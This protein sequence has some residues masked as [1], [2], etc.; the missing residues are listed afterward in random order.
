MSN[1]ENLVSSNPSTPPGGGN[2]G[3]PPA[4][5]RWYKIYAIFMAV[6]YAGLAY[7]GFYFLQN[8][9]VILATTKDLAPDDL[10][11]RAVFLLV[12]GGILA[13][14]F[15]AS[16]F[17]PRTSGAWILKTVLIGVG[18]GNCCLWL[19]TIP[20]MV[21]WLKPETQRWYGRN[22]GNTQN[23]NGSSLIPPA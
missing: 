5:V 17:Q 13:L 12:V 20:L 6:I 18:L 7:L 15:L 22:P 8:P 14:G 16:L 2:D 11:I 1:Q 9:E 3:S 23:S 10:K 19:A 4:V 21:S